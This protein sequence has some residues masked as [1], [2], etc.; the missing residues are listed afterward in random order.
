VTRCGSMATSTGGEVAPERGIGRDYASL[1]DVNL[2][3]S[4]K[5]HVIIQLLQIDDEDLKQ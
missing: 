3:R 2:T 5:I 1:T 4:K